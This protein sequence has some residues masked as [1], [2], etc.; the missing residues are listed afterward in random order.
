M[1]RSGA[2]LAGRVRRS[3]TARAVLAWLGAGY[4][5][6]LGRTMRWQVEG[7]AH[8]DGLL[9]RPDSFVAA[10]WHGRIAFSPLLVPAG[11]QGVAMISDNRDGALIAAV[12]ARFG[13]EAVRGSSF[14]RR[15]RRDKGAAAAY[16]AAHAALARPGTVLAV[17]P[18]GP[19]GPRMRAQAG[20][21][22]LALA[23]GVPVLPV[24]VSARGAILLRSWDRF[25]IPLPFA[26]A[27]V[28]YGPPLAPEDAAPPVARG[29]ARASGADAP[30]RTA[31]MADAAR[32]RAP[33]GGD[34]G[35]PECGHRPRR[36]RLRA[37]APDPGRLI[38]ATVIPRPRPCGY[39]TLGSA[40][41]LEAGAMSPCRGAPRQGL[42]IPVFHRAAE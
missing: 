10:F 14:D 27:V 30:G 38:P 31:P 29:T 37:H 42:S 18:D 4:L 7:G 9:A 39:C 24:A 28:V 20:V 40:K 19:R 41:S 33:Q 21:A 12:A 17:T 35:G 34:R 15:K 2:G 11:R 36:S 13:V 26:R 22:H 8:L 23:A 16:R 32:R 3:G 5:A 1:A 25:L 6:L